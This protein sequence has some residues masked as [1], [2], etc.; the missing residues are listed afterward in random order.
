MG[1]LTNKIIFGKDD[2]LGMDK[3]MRSIG[4]IAVNPHPAIPIPSRINPISNKLENIAASGISSGLNLIP[5][6]TVSKM[7]KAL[8]VADTIYDY[9]TRYGGYLVKGLGWVS[10]NAPYLIGAYGVYRVGDFAYHIYN[11]RKKDRVEKEKDERLKRIE[12]KL[13]HLQRYVPYSS[14]T[15]EQ[16]LLHN[17]ISAAA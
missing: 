15:L 8:S 9:T 2:L 7:G 10:R 3:T 12:E 14:E 13:D 17:G 6:S 5:N 1:R 16:S 11:N 4:N